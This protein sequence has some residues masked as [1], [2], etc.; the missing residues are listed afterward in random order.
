MGFG[1]SGDEQEM[2]KIEFPRSREGILGK[3]KTPCKN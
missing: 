1:N 3:L 2:Y